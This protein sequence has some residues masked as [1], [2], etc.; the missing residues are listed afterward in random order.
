ME[1]HRAADIRNFA[2]VG[3]ASSGKSMLTEAMLYSSGAIN[4]MGRIA[5]GTTASDYHV[6]EKQRQFS[7]QSSIL[8]CEWQGKK[9]NIV[10]SPGYLDFVGESLGALRVADFALVVVHAQHG[11]GVG[12]DRVWK[13]ATEYGIPKIIVVN[14]VDKQNEHFDE[15]LADA[16]AHYGQHGVFPLTIPVN[17]GPKFDQVLD[18]MRSEI[19]TYEQNGRG[20]YK[21]EPAT[22]VWKDKV[23]ALHKELIEH[24]AESD[25]TLLN[26]FF[27]QGSLTEE[28]FRAGIHAALQKQIFIPLFCTSAETNVG[29]ARLMDFIAKYGSSP[30]DRATVTAHSS[31]GAEVEIA[32]EDPE[33][34]L[35]VFKTMAEEHFG[36]LS[37][38]RMYSGTLRSGMD[39]FNSDR[40]TNERIGQIY[41]V[42]GKERQIVPEVGPGDVGAVVKLKDTHT[43]NTLCSPKRIVTLPKVAYPKPTIHAA[44]KAQAAGEEEKV[45][46]GLAAL[47]EE[48]PTFLHRVDSELHQ[49]IL[50]AQGELHLEVLV[51]RLKRR[52]NV[53]V[54][55]AEPRVP[56]RETIH[57]SA[58]SKYRHKKQTGGSGQFAEVWMRIAPAARD[59]GVDFKQSLTGQN[60][61]RVFVPSVERGVKNA[62]NEGILA[63]YKVVDV[64]VDFYD[65][66]MHPVDSNDISFQIAGYFAFKEAFQSARPCLLE[67]IHNVDIHIPEDCL[68]KVMGDLSHRR[69]KILGMDTD[70][71]F[72]VINAQVPAKELYRYSSTLRSLTGG[73]GIHSEEFSHYEEMP[74]DLEQK[75]ATEAKTRRANA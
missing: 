12:T 69:G 68:G 51:D 74:R 41:M 72:Q 6:S 57:A 54:E 22:G 25:D 40:K 55:L 1:K 16:R 60:V 14:A 34:V 20:T 59:S 45:A 38:F 49:T 29:V 56:F 73:R 50:S 65:G 71:Q 30:V 21:E 7:V 75:I 9:F 19:V 18:V 13:Y 64:K 32:L 8:H 31:E 10:D 26:K 4:R 58:E 27:E 39:V 43:G 36:E 67:P 47:H 53:H 48:D 62:C 44:L 5:D 37:F 52:F 46:A 17:P 3:H 35:H 2:I 23:A 66:K 42:N 61:D 33:P 28:E 24:I 15:V 11:I 70:G 63:G